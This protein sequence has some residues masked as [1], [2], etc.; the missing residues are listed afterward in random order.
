VGG[1][2]AE[3]AQVGF[4]RLPGDGIPSAVSDEAAGVIPINALSLVGDFGRQEET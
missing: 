3:K 4:V 2:H 1:D